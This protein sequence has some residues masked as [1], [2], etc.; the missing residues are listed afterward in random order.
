M[1]RKCACPLQQPQRQTLVLWRDC[2][3][4]CAISKRNYQ[5]P[6][7]LTGSN[8]LLWNLMKWQGNRCKVSFREHG[9]KHS[10]ISHR[11]QQKLPTCSYTVMVSGLKKKKHAESPSEVFTR[12]QRCS[13][14]EANYF[15]EKILKLRL[16]C[17]IWWVKYD[18]IPFLSHIYLLL[19][20]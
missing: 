19:V 2:T 9:Q 8:T 16:L 10:K 13:W 1:V 11:Q 3:T 4:A 20:H 12:D 7:I 6:G 14:K 18:R 17:E 5:R 15:G